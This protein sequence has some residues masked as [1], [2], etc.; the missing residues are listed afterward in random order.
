MSSFRSPGWSRE[1]GSPNQNHGN[2]NQGYG[3]QNQGYGN[4]NLGYGNQNRGYGNHGTN[5]S[6]G[7]LSSGNEGMKQNLLVTQIIAHYCTYIE[8]KLMLEK[9]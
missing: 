3:N 2:Q 8:E 4:Q 7:N 5:Q 9:Y 6:Y 1:A